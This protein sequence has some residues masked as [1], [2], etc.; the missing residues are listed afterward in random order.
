MWKDLS[1]E[2]QT[3]FLEAW[4]AFKAGSIPIG[5]VI[6]DEKGNVIIKEHN[7]AR[8]KETL[9]KHIS[10]AEANALRSLDTA[11]YNP[12]T[13]TLYATMEPCPMCMGTAVMSNIK[14]LRYAARDPYCGAVHLKDSDP[15][16]KGQ[17]IDYSH[18]GG[19]MEFVQLTLQSY[20]ELDYI[21]KGAS[22][23]VLNSFR[24]IDE[25]A[26]ALAEKLYPEKRLDMFSGN[27]TDFSEV[28]DFLLSEKEKIE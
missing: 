8:E 4:S 13:L 22:D 23:K 15:Y 17:H 28:Y 3:A 10:H 25:K 5:A 9:N 11:L 26:V 27:V 16:I 20:H 24:S 1:V 14:R 6:A 7:R 19:E 12:K 2:W 21:S 18:V